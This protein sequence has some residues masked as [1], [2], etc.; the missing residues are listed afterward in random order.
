M[1]NFILVEDNNRFNEMLKNEINKIMFRETNDYKIWSFFDFNDEFKEVM[2]KDLSCKIYILD[3]MAPSD[4]GVNIAREIRETD[5]DSIIIF[6]TNHKKFGTILLQDEIMFLSF[7]V[8]SK[9]QERLES[10]IKKALTIVGKKQ[11]IRFIDQKIVYMIPLKD[12][13]YVTTNTV[14]QKTVIRTDYTIF[15]VNKTLIE[16]EKMLDDRFEKSHRSCIVNMDRIVAVN[17][18]LHIITFD[19]GEQTGL[20]ND[21]FKKK[22]ELK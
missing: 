13:L 5:I 16:I 10:A 9:Y 6:L 14:K 1:V 17:K 20:M 4:D 18:K 8:K 11:A 19:N 15:E 12:I 7:I 3:I 22:R 21:E 2:K